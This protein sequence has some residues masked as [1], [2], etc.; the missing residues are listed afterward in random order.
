MSS[1]SFTPNGKCLAKRPPPGPDSDGVGCREGQ[2]GLHPQGTSL[3]SIDHEYHQLQQ[4][5]PRRQ[6]ASPSATAKTWDG[7]GVGRRAWPSPPHPHREQRPHQQSEFQPRCGSAPLPPR[8]RRV[9]VR[10]AE[11]GDARWGTQRPHHQRHR[12]H[13]QGAHRRRHQREFQPRRQAHRLGGRGMVFLT[14]REV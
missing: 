14:A 1:V 6:A 7:Q 8:T 13:P 11:T 10:D 9:R 2:R 3:V 4:F 5:Q 12:P